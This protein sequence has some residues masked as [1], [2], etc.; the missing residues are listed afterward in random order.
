MQKPLPFLTTRGWIF[1]GVFML[2]LLLFAY[3][4]KRHR[5]THP[6]E[7][8]SGYVTKS[9][10]VFTKSQQS[11]SVCEISLE[12]GETTSEN[13]CFSKVGDQINVLIEIKK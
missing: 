6:V 4:L 5:S 11:D 2:F 3:S 7:W 12:N 10:R 1:A 13:H 9:Y 8:K